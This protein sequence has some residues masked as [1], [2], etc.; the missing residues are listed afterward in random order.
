MNLTWTRRNTRG[1][2]LVSCYSRS[3]YLGGR[4]SRSYPL[5]VTRLLFFPVQ[6]YA[7]SSLDEALFVLAALVPPC[8]ISALDCYIWTINLLQSI[9]S[10][11]A[12]REFLT[13]KR[14]MYVH[15]DM[16]YN[17]YDMSISLKAD[18]WGMGK[19]YGE[20][21]GHCFPE[22]LVVFLAPAATAVCAYCRISCSPCAFALTIYEFLRR[23]SDDST[24]EVRTIVDV[25]SRK[26]STSC[27][28]TWAP[29]YIGVSLRISC[30]QYKH[31]FIPLL[32][33]LQQYESL[34]ILGA[35]KK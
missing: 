35:C 18:E 29:F 8:A 2:A 13:K 15:V 23:S 26:A 5:H 24:E 6:Q 14:H 4:R 28:T 20:S 33:Y 10:F 34:Q 16:L 22:E 3:L 30:S 32:V 25:G 9:E 27:A 7:R 1:Y 19:R 17:F 31:W 21:E 11:H 12:C